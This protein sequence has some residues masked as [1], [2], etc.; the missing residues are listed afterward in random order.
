MDLFA[1]YGTVWRHRIVAIPIIL[2]TLIGMV[3]VVKIKAPTYQAT[4]SVLLANPPGPPTAAQVAANPSLA[5]INTSNPYLSYGDLVTV[6]DVVIDVVNS[7]AVAQ[8]LASQGANTKY[9]VTN[10]PLLNDPPIIAITD[11]GPTPAAAEQSTQLVAQQ[12]IKSL[13]Q[14]QADKNVNPYYMITGTEVVKP[15]TAT[16]SS[17]S[18]L[19]TAV[20]VLAIGLI[21]LLIAISAAQA[22]ENRRGSRRRRPRLD[23][24][25]ADAR[26]PEFYPSP[27]GQ[28]MESRRPEPPVRGNGMQSRPIV[29]GGDVTKN[30]GRYR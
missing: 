21:V 30:N 9:T 5:K 23:D 13:R 29:P 22:L 14:M 3:Y 6:S 26:E 2:I 28:G 1:I 16:S 4:A 17:S 19:R 8:S 27:D 18:K 15:T 24:T 10:A 12:T 11:S 20:A 7:P 25:Q